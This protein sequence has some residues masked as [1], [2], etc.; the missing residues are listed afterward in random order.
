MAGSETLDATASKSAARNNN[1]FTFCHDKL[2]L[3]GRNTSVKANKHP[4]TN[5]ISSLMG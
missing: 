5:T 4:G 1:R 2:L 3:L